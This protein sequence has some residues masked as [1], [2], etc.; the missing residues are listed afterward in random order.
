MFN[1]PATFENIINDI[2]RSYFNNFVI[3][4]LNDILIYFK[5]EKK[6]IKHVQ[7][8]IEF[9]KKYKLY[10]KFLKYFFIQKTVEFCGYIRKKKFA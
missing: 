1:T 5:N 4:Y 2:L 10:I 9:L 6:N 7:K 3:I 8:V